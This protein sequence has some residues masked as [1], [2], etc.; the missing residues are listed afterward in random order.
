MPFSPVIRAD[1]L[2][3]TQRVDAAERQSREPEPV[4]LKTWLAVVG[5][6]I[7]AFLAVLNIQ[8][9]N[10]ALLDIQG[11]IGAGIDD[12]GWVATSYLV[13]EIIVIPLSG[14]LSRVF[15]LRIYLIVNTALFLIFS[16]GCATSHSL[17]QM[18]AW[19][20]F[21]GA[22][23]GVLIPLAFT[24]IMTMLPKGKQPIGLTMFALGA[25]F[26]PAIGPTIGGWLNEAY[27]W[28]YI[29]YVNLAPGAF[30]LVLLF[31][32]LEPAPLN[33]P[34]LRRGDWAGIV[35]MALALGSLQTVLEEG[36][37]DDWFGS[38]FI[39]RLSAISAISFVLF[40]FIEFRSAEPVLELRLLARRNFGFAT[41]ANGLLGAA[42]YGSTYIL[43]LYLAQIQGYNAEQIGEVV[44]WVGLPQLVLIP[45]VPLLVRWFDS[46]ILVAAG[47]ALFAASNLMDIHVS[48]DAAGPQLFWPNI[49]RAVG[50]AVILAP[51]AGIAT[52]GIERRF[53]PSASAL[54][55][56]TR[57]LGGAIGIAALETL[58]TKREQ[59]HSNILS[60]AVSELDQ[61]T[62]LRIAQMT[63]YFASQG[64]DAAVAKHEAIVA[65]GNSIRQQSFIMAYSDMFALMGLAVIGAIIA[66]LFVKRTAAGSETVSG[67]H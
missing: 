38:P 35:T 34:L 37:K 32:S 56:M 61:A 28:Q 58:L 15:S 21:Q 9:V 13:T 6:N 52:A 41:L 45:F 59:F 54:F 1:D 30:M 4:A 49:V 23:G 22:S 62:R 2:A 65:I 7:G 11:A 66:L 5:V 16:A 63:Q 8:I 57:N 60:A 51:L 18:I 48:L 64:A 14:W 26:A 46:R 43:P 12:G 53:A 19:R 10:S 44:A 25:T 24:V 31:V 20:A 17:G 67:G 39:V 33:L 36:N 42:L 29:F 40:L 27:G 3:G 47:L 50:Q 55:N